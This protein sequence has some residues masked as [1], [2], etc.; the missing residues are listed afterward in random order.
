VCGY[1]LS[2]QKVESITVRSAD[3]TLRQPV[4]GF[5]SCRGKLIEHIC[6]AR[7]S[8]YSTNTR[9]DC[10]TNGSRR[11]GG[12]QPKGTPGYWWTPAPPEEI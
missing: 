1:E 11:D 4:G 6:H 7:K 10:Q 8:L 5:P 9:R 2:I 3:W 12:S